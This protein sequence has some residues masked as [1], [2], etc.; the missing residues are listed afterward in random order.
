MPVYQTNIFI[1]DG[2]GK[3][4]SQTK[5]EDLYGDPVINPPEGWTYLTC[6]ACQKEANK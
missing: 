6:P 2:C 4:E 1:C 5:E 3:I